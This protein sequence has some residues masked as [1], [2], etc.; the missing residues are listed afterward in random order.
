MRTFGNIISAI[1]ILIAVPF[2]IA[3][4]CNM[5]LT[6]SLLARA[7][8]EDVLDDA[9]IFET[10]SAAVLPAIASASEVELQLDGR[11]Q[12]VD[13]AFA[14]EDNPDV[15]QQIAA[16][17]VPADW[18]QE[19][20]TQIVDV[21]FLILE[22]EASAIDTEFDLTEVRS[23]LQGEAAEEAAQTIIITAPACTAD[24]TAELTT[25]FEED[26][27]VNLP[28]CQPDTRE[29]TEASIAE[30]IAWFNDIGD[31]L[32]EDTLTVSEMTAVTR[33]DARAAHLVFS[34]MQQSFLLL[35]LCPMALMSLVIILSV[36]NLMG[37]GIWIGGAVIVTG[38]IFVLII[39]LAQV[40]AF[41]AIDEAISQSTATDAETI[42]ASRIGTALGLSVLRTSSA[43]L[44]AQ[45]AGFIGVGFVI[46]ALAWYFNRQDDTDDS[47]Y[48]ITEDG[49]I[50]S[51][52]TQQRVGSVAQSQANLEDT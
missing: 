19:T 2:F 13:I 52:A 7:T 30:L 36:R 27:E 29:R 11:V 41:G 49:D 22:G 45:S 1:L 31:A 23:R 3:A 32:G 43:T 24:Q 16:S 51:T 4:G 6:G 50:V 34:L 20:V 9:V 10:V 12:V 42:F 47:I 44:L 46:L 14:L 39:V 48:F 21:F 8:Y 17:L 18:L 38:V 28:I 5:A 37:F 15:A 35:F 25:Y 33:D 40:A 26:G